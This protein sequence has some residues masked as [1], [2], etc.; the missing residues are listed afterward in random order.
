MVSIQGAICGAILPDVARE[1][2]QY[3]WLVILESI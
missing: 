2:V 3:R 1:I